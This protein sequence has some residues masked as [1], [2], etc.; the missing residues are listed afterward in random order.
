MVT[1]RDKVCSTGKL[2]D[3]VYI[4]D[5]YGFVTIQCSP[6]P[7]CPVLH[8]LLASSTVIS[9]RWKLCIPGLSCSMMIVAESCV[10]ENCKILEMDYTCMPQLATHRSTADTLV[11]CPPILL[12]NTLRTPMNAIIQYSGT[13]LND[14]Q[15]FMKHIGPRV[16]LSH[17]QHQDILLTHFTISRY[18][19]AQ[20]L[21]ESLERSR[22]H[23][24]PS[25]ISFKNLDSLILRT[26]FYGVYSGFS[27]A[28]EHH[29][30]LPSFKSF[31]IGFFFFKSWVII[32]GGVLRF[33][34]GASEPLG[35]IPKTPTK[36]IILASFLFLSCICWDHFP[37]LLCRL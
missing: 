22:A 25:F 23:I 12:K 18:S 33:L 5:A 34:T 2:V 15:Y 7:L 36:K 14:P 6:V 35:S 13:I 27:F 8:A 19:K 31:A 37:G 9:L 17:K 4:Y 20:R 11:L 26:T 1:Q 32:R 24:Y 28:T 30:F 16:I 21:G 10:K 29:N 3:S